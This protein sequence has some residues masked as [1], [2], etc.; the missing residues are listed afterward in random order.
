MMLSKYDIFIFDI[1]GGS[2]DVKITVGD[3]YS[4]TCSDSPD[5]SYTFKDYNLTVSGQGGINNYSSYYSA[6]GWKIDSYVKNAVIN[7]GVDYI[8]YRAFY[9]MKNLENVFIPKS[10][11]SIDD[12]AFSY[13][14]YVGDSNDPYAPASASD[15]IDK[16]MDY[17]TI[18]GY[19]GSYAETFAKEK[20]IPFVA[21]DEVKDNDTNIEVAGRLEDGIELEV[22]ELS[23]E[24]ISIDEENKAVR[25]C[26]DISLMKDK[27]EVQPEMPVTVKI[28]CS[29]NFTNIEVYRINDDDSKDKVLSN[30][31][32]EYITF[33]TDHFSKYAI[34]TNVGIMGDT[35][36]DG[37]AT[38]AD[39]L[40]I[41]RY[42]V[43]L[44]TLTNEQL[45]VSDVNYDGKV[46]IADALKIARYEVK[47]I[48]SL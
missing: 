28:P 12:T 11:R 34:V 38:I 9:N 37:K 20:N 14:V 45:A 35:N 16:T 3:T 4:D 6:F 22:N 25:A 19:S 13:Q 18:Y 43:K 36:G 5:I 2:S 7:E 31:D 26:F 1:S 10:V 23:V 21:V 15:L 48:D 40:M 17:I 8:G 27:K 41:A 39:S 46:T 33:V 24:E 32:G 44:R 47:L 30:Y 29:G 42:E